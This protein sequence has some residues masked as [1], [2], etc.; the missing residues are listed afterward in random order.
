MKKYVDLGNLLKRWRTERYSSLSELCEAHRLSVGPALLERYELGDDLAPPELLEEL[1][2]ALGHD[3]REALLA[4]AQ[5]QAGATE[6]KAFFA[7]LQRPYATA[8][9]PASAPASA[10]PGPESRAPIDSNQIPESAHSQ[11]TWVF[12][13]HEREQLARFPW[14]LDFLIGLATVFPSS[15][16]YESYGFAPEGKELAIFRDRYL[17][18]WLKQGQLIADE[19]GFRIAK[20]YIHMPKTPEWQDIRDALLSRVIEC[21]IPQMSAEK[22]ARRESHRT[23]IHKILTEEQFKDWIARLAQLEMEFSLVPN[24]TPGE[25]ARIV[26][27]LMLMA[28]RELRLP[29]HITAA[30]PRKSVA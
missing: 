21:L 14:L 11:Q 12:G 13:E 6:H 28:P 3:V 8:R 25:G 18:S 17:L 26:S 20:P 16:S 23:F 15:R 19:Q 5:A 7:S 24:G 9:V 2:R 10:G 22:I 29:A 27:L 30:T 1:A 4:W